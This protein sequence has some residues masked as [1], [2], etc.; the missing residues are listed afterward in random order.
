MAK[1]P[2]TTAVNRPRKA[3][4]KSRTATRK[5]SAAGKRKA[6]QAEQSRKDLSSWFYYLAMGVAAVILL[7]FLLLLYPPV[8]IPLETLFGFESL[9]CMSSLWL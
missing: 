9:W 6:K 8:C 2:P 5:A 4:T 3:G 7:H 1:E